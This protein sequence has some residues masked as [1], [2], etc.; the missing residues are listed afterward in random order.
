LVQV[1]TQLFIGTLSYSS[2]AGWATLFAKG[3]LMA[4]L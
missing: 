2:S 1:F 4:R 3:V